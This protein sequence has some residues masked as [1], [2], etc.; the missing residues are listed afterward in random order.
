M[1]AANFPAA[2]KLVLIHEGGL[3]PSCSDSVSNGGLH[4]EALSQKFIQGCSRNP[5]KVG[6]VFDRRGAAIPHHAFPLVGGL[7]RQG[8]P[9]AISRLIAPIVVDAVKRRPGGTRPHV[10]Q[11]RL[12][13]GGPAGAHADPSP[14]ISR[15]LFVR[16]VRTT[17]F[18]APPR[19]MF[20]GKRKAVVSWAS[21]DT[22]DAHAPAARSVAG[23]KLVARG[24]GRP[25]TVTHAFPAGSLATRRRAA[26]VS[27]YHPEASVSVA[28]AVYQLRHRTRP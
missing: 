18:R 1:T 26:V 9:S 14:T 6:K 28:S 21:A 8:G 16:G 3:G 10:G 7:L 20:R 2:L 17:L 23:R 24:D 11:E 12:K 13:R 25:A 27:R 22:F 15:E 4:R 19:L 5:N